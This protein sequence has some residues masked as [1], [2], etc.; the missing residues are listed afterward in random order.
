MMILGFGAGKG[1]RGAGRPGEFADVSTDRKDGAEILIAKAGRAEL[2]VSHWECRMEAVSN[3]QVSRGSATLLFVLWVALTGGWVGARAFA[4]SPESAKDLK[5]FVG[6]WKASFQGAPLAILILKD[7]DGKLRGTLN[8]FDLVF[9]KDGNLADGSH[10]DSGD[11]PLLNVRFKSG[12]LFFTV[13]EKDQYRPPNDW[14]FV[15][16]NAQEGELTPLLEHQENA[17]PGIVAKPIRMVRENP[18]P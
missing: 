9:D 14:K 13:I 4:Q 11:A 5:A 10:S 17:A 1:H 8:D 6:T 16:L 18:K 7:Q 2:P 15:P 3:R 12:V